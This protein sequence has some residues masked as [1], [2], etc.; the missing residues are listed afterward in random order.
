MFALLAH[1]E[2]PPTWITI[3]MVV[4]MLA[5]S[6]ICI[7]FAPDVIAKTNKKDPGEIVIDE[8][9]GQSV[10]FIPAAMLTGLPP[11]LAAALG[12]ALFR[13]FDITKPIPIK[14]LEKLPAGVGILADDLM[15]GVYAAIVLVFLPYF[16]NYLYPTIT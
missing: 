10:T 13:I 15:A 6:A 5:A 7:A 8:L 3:I 2:M 14:K 4:W 1:F 16:Y 12:F 9:A 11:L